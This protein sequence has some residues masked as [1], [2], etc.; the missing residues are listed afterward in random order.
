MN[1]YVILLQD[2]QTLVYDILSAR[3]VHTDVL[4]EKQAFL[5]KIESSQ[6]NKLS[7]AVQDLKTYLVLLQHKFSLIFDTAQLLLPIPSHYSLRTYK[8]IREVAQNYKIIPFHKFI[9][10]QHYE[11][12]TYIF[13]MARETFKFTFTND[14]EVT[15]YVVSQIGFVNLI[16]QIQIL[17]KSKQIL[18][19]DQRC[20]AFIETIDFA[21]DLAKLKYNQQIFKVKIFDILECIKDKIELLVKD[22]AL[23]LPCKGSQNIL[24]LIQHDIEI[25]PIFQPIHQSSIVDIPIFT[26]PGDVV[27]KVH[28]QDITIFTEDS[29][30]FEN[31]IQVQHTDYCEIWQNNQLNSAWEFA[32]PLDTIIV[33]VTENYKLIINNAILVQKR[34]AS[35][36]NNQIE[37]SK[38][39]ELLSM[40]PKI[41]QTRSNVVQTQSIIANFKAEYTRFLYFV[42][43]NQFIY[44]DT[45][46]TYFFQIKEDEIFK[47]FTFGQLN[48]SWR[49][50]VDQQ[51]QIGVIYTGPRSCKIILNKKVIWQGEKR[52]VNN[53]Q[54]IQE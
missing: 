17:L 3:L 34:N 4:I 48:S 36:L 43:K 23:H 14:Y 50:T 25:I 7:E 6:G 37:Q 2:Q 42:I 13:M 32:E 20:L 31:T 54:I 26:I 11:G 53:I 1:G 28:D 35:Q 8:L 15:E 45:S 52:L 44:F 12:L 24:K 40:R 47:I 30:L 19:S 21:Q 33:R 16:E 18:I 29:K 5:Y 51:I 39:N 49:S 9:I 27:I 41:Q 38:I 10:N 46:D 22:L